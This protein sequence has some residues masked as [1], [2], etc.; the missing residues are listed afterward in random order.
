MLE[1][2]PP[3]H[4]NNLSRLYGNT[5]PQY[6]NEMILQGN[7]QAK[8][9]AGALPEGKKAGTGKHGDGT[10]KPWQYQQVRTGKKIKT[11]KPKKKNK[12]KKKNNAQPNSAYIVFNYGTS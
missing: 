9:A 1:I 11:N 5:A 10:G 8:F 6:I 3:L 4:G 7:S 12:N 2:Q